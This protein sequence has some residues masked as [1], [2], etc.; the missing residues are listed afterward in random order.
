MALIYAEL[1]GELDN[2]RRGELAR[3]LLADP[4]ARALRDQLQGLCRR[5]DTVR[6]VEPPPQLRDSILERLPPVAAGKAKAYPK[7]SV[8]RWRL[9]AV[10][11]GLVTAGSIV[12]ELVQGPGPGTREIA[13]TMVSETPVIVDSVAV[14]PG[15]V[16]GHV[17]LYRDKGSL[18]VGLGISA[19]EPVDVLVASGGRSFRIKGLNTSSSAGATRTIALPG[20]AMQGQAVELEF[21]IGER[22]VSRATLHAPSGP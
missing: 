20:V 17:S 13:G 10:L 3:L 2:P 16:T 11:A 6:Q 22:T 1:D 5:L 19:T 7:A 8:S 12:Y 18:L 4:Q 21:L 9:A 14:Q 15:P